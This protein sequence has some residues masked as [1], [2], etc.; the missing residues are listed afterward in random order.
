[1]AIATIEGKK[2]NIQDRSVLFEFTDSDGKTCE[3]SD[4]LLHDPVMHN[5]L[6]FTT[7]LSVLKWWVANRKKLYEAWYE[8]ACHRSLFTNTIEMYFD[9][10]FDILMDSSIEE[11]KRRY[12]GSLRSPSLRVVSLDGSGTEESVLF[13][14]ESAEEVIPD[15]ELRL[16]YS[17]NIALRDG[18]TRGR[19][20]KWEK[21]WNYTFKMDPDDFDWFRKVK[22]EESVM[23]GLE[24]EVSTKLS[25]REIQRIIT[26]VEPKQDP[27]FIFKSDSSISGKFHNLVEIV[28]VPCT[29]RY[30]RKNWKIFFQKLQKLCEAKNLSV[31]DVFDT[32]NSLSNGLHIHVSNSDFQSKPHKRRFLTAWNQWNKS[33]TRL[34]NEISG[35]PHDYT[36]HT[37]CKINYEY[38]GRTLA[39]RLKG[40][41]CGDRQS[42]AHDQSGS[43]V[44]VRVYQGIFDLTHILRCISFTEAVFE[45]S[46]QMGYKDFDMNFSNALSKFIKTKRKYAALY[47]LLQEKLTK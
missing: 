45:F 35:R 31:S 2:Y 23:F 27:F 42:V 20:N 47:S 17:F 7:V 1:M 5:K 24:L 14:D 38:D 44:E 39:R 4:K 13:E 21:M 11:L 46:Q 10:R 25:R 43:T 40:I 30:L 29:P 18:S 33:S 12:E 8:W 9:R 28:T 37:Y 19:E 26:E 36:R 32:S 34:F 16:E 6:K 41:S 15:V 22:Y 3:I